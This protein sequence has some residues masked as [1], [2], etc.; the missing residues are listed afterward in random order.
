M[1]RTPM[2]L[3]QIDKILASIEGS[4][5]K[6]AE[7]HTEA[8]SIGGETTHPVKNVDDNTTKATEGFRSKENESDVKETVGKPG[9]NSASE[10][11]TG[12]QDS[13]QL[14]IGVNA[15]ETGKDVPSAKGGKQDGGTYDGKSTHPARTDN[16]SLEGGK[17]ASVKEATAVLRGRI[18]Q[19]QV[20][21]NEI[22]G[23]MAVS[24][25]KPTAP[26]HKQAAVPVAEEAQVG[27]DFAG[28]VSQ[29]FDKQA[30]HEA[31]VTGL[32]ETVLIGET[33]A[34]KV[35]EYLDEFFAYAKT[36]GDEEGDMGESSGGDGDGDESSALPYGDAGGLPGMDGGDAGGGDPMGAGGPP[37]GAGGDPGA[38]GGNPLQGI[39]PPSPATAVA[40]A[41]RPTRRR[42]GWSRWCGRRRSV[43]DAARRT[44]HGRRR[45]DVRHGG[46][47]RRRC[48]WPSARSRCG[49]WR[50]ASSRRRPNGHVASS[51]AHGRYESGCGRSSG[52]PKARRFAEGPTGED[53]R[54]GSGLASQERCSTAASRSHGWVPAR[55]NRPALST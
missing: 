37:P 7:A 12:G 55:T 31:V 10:V 26:A 8:G 25:T 50:N 30:F 22:M 46:S 1:S 53:R 35:A 16:D 14:N 9:V 21:G 23:A 19:A 44:K 45:R 13:V 11:T 54:Q 15:G 29:D 49:R 36:A 17:Y 42:C 38:G 41:P 18:K 52:S 40:S 4:H 48:G 43:G 6:S 2:V 28:T 33:Q 39:D 5:N 32:A 34:E 27:Y 51:D 47:G 24:A 20:L 3:G